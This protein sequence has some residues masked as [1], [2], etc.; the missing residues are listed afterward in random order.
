MAVRVTADAV[1]SAVDGWLRALVV[2]ENLCPFAGAVVGQPALRLVHTPAACEE[3][4]LHALAEELQ[5][6]QEQPQIETTVL[7][8]P[9]VL[10]AFFDYN[11][12]LDMADALLVQLS[13]D[14]VFQIASFH[15]QYQFANTEPG[16]A[17]NYANRAPYPLLHL[18]RE[19]S[20]ARAVAQH[21]DVA[22][23]P[24]RNIARL[25]QIGAAELAARLQRWR[26]VSIADV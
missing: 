26:P 5:R 11:Q 7:V 8:H 19:S 23:I 1:L 12:F 25:E 22:N 6:L 18:L 3:D 14:G 2:G 21:P 16:A 24:V 9:N 4:L 20:V 10:G 13:L 17:E 15:P